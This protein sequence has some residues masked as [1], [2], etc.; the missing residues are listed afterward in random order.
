MSQRPSLLSRTRICLQWMVNWLLF[1][2]FGG[3]LL[4]I[5]HYILGIRVVDREHHRKFYLEL[6]R[7]RTPLII[8]ANHLTYI[9][10]VVLIYAFART[11]D[12]FTKFRIL[13][14][15][16]PAANYR[17]NPFF[18]LVGM[19]SK[20]IFIKRTGSAAQK[21]QVLN[22]ARWIV[23]HGEPLTIFPEGRRSTTGRY[24]DGRLAYGIGKIMRTLPSC[25]VLCVYSRADDQMGKSKFPSRNAKFRIRYELL[26]FTGEELQPL[27]A[28]GTTTKKI[29]ETIQRLETLHFQELP[30]LHVSPTL[31]R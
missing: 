20:C 17:A 30:S 24:D 28:V 22:E 26:H 21:E 19:L 18:L 5:F 13:S 15:N 23:A 29:A 14:W 11:W 7:D 25:R 3:V 12:Y 8:C 31:P 27:S 2:P 10:S 16:L 1:L 9:D 4:Q 6:T